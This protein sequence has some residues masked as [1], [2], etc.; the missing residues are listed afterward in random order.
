MEQIVIYNRAGQVKYDLPS[1]D[2]IYSP[3]SAKLQRQHMA[4]DF[5]QLNVQ[6][7]A[8]LSLSIGDYIEVRGC[9]YAIRAVSDV[10][11][12][13]EDDFTYAITMYGA[14]YWLM[15]YRYRDTPINGRSAQNTFDLTLSLKDFIK[16]IINNVLRGEGISAADAAN[17]SPWLFDEDSCPDTDPK[18]MSFDKLNCLT[19]LQNICKEFDVEFR[20][21]QA[22]NATTNVWQST[23]HVG[24]FGSV[25]N[26]TPFAYGEGNGLY[27]LQETKVDDSCIVNRIWSEGSTENILSGYRGYSMRLQLPR[28]NVPRSHVDGDNDTYPNATVRYTRKQHTIEIDG[29]KYIFKKGFPIGIDADA[30]RY[31]DEA[32][33]YAGSEHPTRGMWK[34]EGDANWHYAPFNPSGLITNYG[35]LEDS[36]V[37][38]DIKPSPTFRVVQILSTDT[39]KSFFVDV[40]FDL[41]A[42]WTD[43]YANFREWCLLKTNLVPSES[44]YNDCKTVH[45]NGGTGGT[46]EQDRE[47][48][49]E[50]RQGIGEG[51][52][53][54]RI[55]P[56]RQWRLTHQHAAAPPLPTLPGTY[57]EETYEEYCIFRDYVLSGA[58]SKYLIDGG[59]MAVIDGTCAG[60]DFSVASFKFWSNLTNSQKSEVA[61][62][63]NKSY[64]VGDYCIRNNTPYRCTTAHQGNWNS[65]HFTEAEFGLITICTKEEQD[66]GYIFPSEDEL[67]AFRIK[68]GD[69]FKLVSIYFPYRYYEDAEEDLWFASWEK[70]EAVKYP[71][72]RYKLTFDQMFVDEN[73]TI[74]ESILP[75]DY[76]TISD[77]RFGLTNKKMRVTQVDCNLLNN[78]DYQLTLDSVHKQRTRTGWLPVRFDEVYEAVEAMRMDNPRWRRNNR[79]SGSSALSYMTANGAMRA[80]RIADD[81]IIARM[82]ANSAVTDAKLAGNISASKL[83][84]DI[85][86]TKLAGDISLALLSSAVREQIARFENRYDMLERF[87]NSIYSANKH[88]TGTITFANNKL[89]LNN[90]KIYDGY[91]KARLGQKWDFWHNSSE[92]PI[93]FSSGYEDGKAYVILGELKSDG[94]LGYLAVESGKENDVAYNGCIKI[95]SVSKVESGARSYTQYI[96]TSYTED[97]VIRDGNGRAVLDILSG[98]LK[99]RSGAV[100]MSLAEGYINSAAKVLR[101]G[102][103]TFTLADEIAS[104]RTLRK[105]FTGSETGTFN[106]KDAQ[107]N[108]VNIQGIL[109]VLPSSEGGLRHRLTNVETTKADANNVWQKSQCYINPETGAII[110]GENSATPTT[111]ENTVS[112]QAFNT[113]KQQL[114]HTFHQIEKTFGCNNI[115]ISNRDH[116]DQQTCTI[117]SSGLDY[118]GKSSQVVVDA[119]TR[120][121]DLYALGGKS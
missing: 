91:S 98:L 101:G 110:I 75:G 72:M 73:K 115:V 70:F 37:F 76:I 23:I 99:D 118:P 112:L 64:A 121:A 15:R 108:D 31:V 44:D 116:L 66:T 62:S 95:G 52:I 106:F 69:Q 59:S 109:G 97:G 47:L 42:L 92:Y 6:S 90:V 41:A 94:S 102:A 71:S 43:T 117:D 87:G 60:I 55:D 38:D 24:Q 45:D 65:G 19:A 82:L 39:R 51:L 79:T 36:V 63:S 56:Y 54:Y 13:G 9:R 12:S 104:A 61:F 58:N 11:R 28:K 35:I 81:T 113:Y 107:G 68:P 93:D 2:P 78:N 25:V 119:S 84:G 74:F 1:E 57:D 86:A 14:M 105:Y 20:I 114:A 49:V 34:K 17:N 5:V 83:A 21:T 85:P 7:T 67:G 120:F 77:D 3:Q 30:S 10:T 8:T 80:D 103:Q 48:W 26:N 89:V 50:Y 33:L 96:G 27:Q 100:L 88:Y 111:I 40:D 22:E 18:T 29:E 32:N 4:N 16:V 46:Y 53:D